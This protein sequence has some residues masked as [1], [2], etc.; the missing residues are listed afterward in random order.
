MGHLKMMSSGK[1]Q[2][3]PHGIIS[4][5]LEMVIGTH[6]DEIKIIEGLKIYV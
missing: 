1:T 5:G 2:I 4:R 3:M 6:P